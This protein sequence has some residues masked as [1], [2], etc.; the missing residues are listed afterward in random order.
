ANAVNFA[1]AK[2]QKATNQPSQDSITPAHVQAAL[3]QARQM[4]LD[5]QHQRKNISQ[6]QPIAAY[7]L[8]RTKGQLVV[9]PIVLGLTDDTFY[10]VLTGLSKNETIVAGMQANSTAFSNKS[11]ENAS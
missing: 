2:A 10:E 4:L 6:D 11:K 8:E 5:L 9:K 1:Q 7:V 3:A